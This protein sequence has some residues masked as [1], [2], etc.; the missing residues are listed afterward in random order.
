MNN[1][2]AAT[3]YSQQI[4]VELKTLQNIETFLKRLDNIK[5]DESF[6]YVEARNYIATRRE[7][8]TMAE[9]ARLAA[10][11]FRAKSIAKDV[12]PAASAVGS[13]EPTNEN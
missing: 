7:M 5:G 1:N 4:Q 6:A 3:E 2:N 8:I 9:N 10:Q 12:T 11:K 13:S